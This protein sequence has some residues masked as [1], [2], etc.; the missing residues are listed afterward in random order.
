MIKKITIV[1]ETEEDDEKIKSHVKKWVVENFTQFK[2]AKIKIEEENGNQHN[3]N[4]E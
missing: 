3:K 2:D 1:V 4:K